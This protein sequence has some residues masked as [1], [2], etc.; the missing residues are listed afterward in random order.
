[1]RL[2]NN[3]ATATLFLE[4]RRKNAENIYPVKLKLTYQRER[5]Y[6]SLNTDLSEADFE[7]IMNNTARG[8]L[9]DIQ[10]S[11][12]SEK[13]RANDIIETMANFNFKDFKR[14]FGIKSTTRTLDWFFLNYIDKLKANDQLRNAENYQ[15]AY[16]RLTSFFKKDFSFQ[17]L[18]ASDLERFE[19]ALVKEGKSISTVGV[20]VRALRAIYNQAIVAGAISKEDYPFGIGKFVVPASSKRKIGLPIDFIRIIAQHK[21]EV[22]KHSFYRDLFLVSFYLNGINMK[23]IAFMKYGQISNDVLSYVRK[24]TARTK[25]Q[26][27]QT[28][29]VKLNPGVKSIIEKWGTKPETADQYIFPILKNEM[30]S[31]QQLVAYKQATKMCSKMVTK[32]AKS[33]NWDINISFMTARH[34]F[35]NLLQKNNQ[36]MHVIQQAL[37]HSDPKTTMHYLSDL[38]EEKLTEISNFTI[39]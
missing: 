14:L 10:N 32:I 1:M 27:Q 38:Q 26:N 22:P 34:S 28:I 29:D 21:L 37:G 13:A 2:I 4:N 5:I 11:L 7:K 3:K 6:M 12:E 39:L 16:N 8:K 17:R 9:R 30:N 18:S 36:P 24:K 31:A 33:N 25:R 20:Y 19:R 15:S 23:D 35:G